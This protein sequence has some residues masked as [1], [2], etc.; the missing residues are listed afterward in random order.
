MADISF[1]SKV[2]T[3]KFSLR[4]IA[5]SEEVKMFSSSR[6]RRLIGDFPFSIKHFQQWVKSYYKCSKAI[7]CIP[8]VKN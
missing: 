3:E 8:E 7:P 1:A 2:Y 6:A 5:M 4:K